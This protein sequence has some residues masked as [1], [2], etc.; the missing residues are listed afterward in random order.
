MLPFVLVTRVHV[1]VRVRP[2][3]CCACLEEKG[4]RRGGRGGI[5]RK[6]KVEWECEVS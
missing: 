1:C 5:G 4:M 6:G 2:R 3:A